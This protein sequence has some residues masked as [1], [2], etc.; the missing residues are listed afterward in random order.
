M[1]DIEEWRAIPGYEGVYEAST[2]GRIRSL[3][4]YIDVAAARGHTRAYRQ[5]RYGC[6]LAPCKSSTGHLLV[7][8][9][10]TASE[11]KKR[12]VHTLVLETFRG[13]RPTPLHQARHLNG[14][15]TDNRLTNLEWA[16]KKRNHQDVKHHKGQANYKL[17]PAQIRLI[18]EGLAQGIQGK[19][20]AKQFGVSQPTISAIKHGNIHTDVP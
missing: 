3:D 19:L 2:L 13:I 10:P 9:G 18:R 17:R 15:E 4:R 11:Q 7:K 14:C 12:Y 8:V 6:V 5:R 16:T 20:L 1:A